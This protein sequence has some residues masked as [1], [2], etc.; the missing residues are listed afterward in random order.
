M[1]VLGA[2]RPMAVLL[3]LWTWAAVLQFPEGKPNRTLEMVCCEMSDAKVQNPHYNLII[4]LVIEDR[5]P[6]NF[7]QGLQRS[8]S[9]LFISA[10]KNMSYAAG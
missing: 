6:P 5:I 10:R 8:T 4:S 1:D 7:D 2:A 9:L 3:Y